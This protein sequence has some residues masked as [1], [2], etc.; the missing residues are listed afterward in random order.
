VKSVSSQNNPSG[1]YTPQ[2]SVV[3][4]NFTPKNSGQD[5]SYDP[6]TYLQG[7]QKAL[8]GLSISQQQQLQQQQAEQADVTRQQQDQRTIDLDKLN[9]DHPPHSS[10]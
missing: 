10:Q 1:G 7:A 3:D 8:E 2:P 6:M 4:P 9:T 5:V